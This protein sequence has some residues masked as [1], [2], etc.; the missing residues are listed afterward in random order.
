MREV[1]FKI[2]RRLHANPDMNQRDL[3]QELGVSLGKVNYCLRGLAAKG[4][5]KARRFKNSRNKRGYLYKL[6][7]KGIE[8]KAKVTY[9]FLQKRIRE[10]EALEREIKELSH[11]MEQ[12]TRTEQY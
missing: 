11:E 12:R 7:P 5:V 10:Y 8:E 2:L 4:L 9:H 1:D 3:A 6:T